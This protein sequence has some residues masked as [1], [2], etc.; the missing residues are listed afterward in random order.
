MGKFREKLRERKGFTLVEMIIVIAII[1]VLSGVIGVGVHGYLVNA[2]MTRVN[3]TAKTVFLAAQNYITEQKQLGKL[4]EFNEKAED[5][6]H[7]VDLSEAEVE[8]IILANHSNDTQYL[9]DYEKK[10]RIDHI[11][12]ITLNAGEQSESSQ[13]P[14]DTIVRTS[15]PNLAKL[16]RNMIAALA[17]SEAC[18]PTLAASILTYA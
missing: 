8:N 13:N 14:I 18:D 7:A 11:R 15:M 4:E 16:R 2:Y 3:D 9:S 6:G 10:Y 12:Y 17:E 5:Y 1:A